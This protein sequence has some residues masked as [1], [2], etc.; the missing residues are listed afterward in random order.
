MAIITPAVVDGLLLPAR[1]L[2]SRVNLATV[3]IGVVVKEGA[4]KAG[5]QH[6]GG[7][8][9]CA[10]RGQIGRLHRSRRAAAPAGFTSTNCSSGLASPI[11]CGR[12]PSSRK[13]AH[14]ADLIVSGEAELGVHQISEIVPVKGAAL[15]G[16]LPKEIQNTTTYAA[17]LA[18]RRRTRRRRR[19]HQDVFW[20]GRPRCSNPKAWSR[21]TK[22]E[23]HLEFAETR[24][25]IA[26]SSLPRWASPR[27]WPGVHRS[28][29]PRCSPNR[30]LQRP[31]GRSVGWSVAR[32]SACSLQG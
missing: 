32:R 12:R 17:G 9:E 26:A 30:S 4:R 7:L 18:R 29:F 31:A 15:V 3:S 19:P 11:R 5:H 24:R 25:S 27:S 21:P 16:P 14:V 20:S 10:A 13:A 1:S 8:Q 2:Q 23:H 28:I 6:G 22:D